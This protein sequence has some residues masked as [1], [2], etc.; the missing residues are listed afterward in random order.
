[1]KLSQQNETAGSRAYNWTRRAIL[2]GRFPEGS[3]LEEMVVCDETSV[4]RTPVREALHRLAAEGYLDLLPRR[5]A[6]VRRVTA[7]DLIET[8]EM[9]SLLEPHGFG[10]VCTKQVVLPASIDELLADMEESTRLDKIKAGDRLAISDHAQL[11]FAFHSSLIEAAGNSVLT[12]LFMSL[13]P[14]HQR[15]GVSAVTARPGRV[16]LISEEHR[17]I[18]DALKKFDVDTAT[19]TLRTHLSPDDRVVAHLR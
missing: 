3:F 16:D 4:S 14:R 8:Y 15:I 6:Q 2:D 11:D 9:R 7:T 10:L 12:E 1:M 17:K 18:L 13:Q 5:G 19:N